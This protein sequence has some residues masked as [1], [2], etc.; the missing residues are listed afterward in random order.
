[1]ISLIEL[2]AYKTRLQMIRRMVGSLQYYCFIAIKHVL[3][4]AQTC[5]LMNWEMGLIA[6]DVGSISKNGLYQLGPHGPGPVR[7]IASE[8]ASPHSSYS[9]VVG[10]THWRSNP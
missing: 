10:W 8:F 5:H 3:L 6:A 4:Q 9:E 1:M 2:L 7:T